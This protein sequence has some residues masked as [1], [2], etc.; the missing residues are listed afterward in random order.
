[1]LDEKH[2]GDDSDDDGNDLPDVGIQAPYVTQKSQQESAC[3]HKRANSG[4]SG[5]EVVDFGTHSPQSTDYPLCY[6][7]LHLIT[8]DARFVV[9]E[10]VGTPINEGGY[11]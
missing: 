2:K 3:N 11:L 4:L 5:H 9:N 7:L 6:P 1:M 8:Q 10:A